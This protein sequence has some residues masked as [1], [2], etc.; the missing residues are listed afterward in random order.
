MRALILGPDGALTV[1]SASA[2]KNNAERTK[3][4]ESW[5]RRVRNILTPPAAAVGLMGLADRRR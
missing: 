3:R 5:K 2:D 4:V 1:H